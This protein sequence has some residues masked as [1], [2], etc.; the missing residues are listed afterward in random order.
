[1]FDRHMNTYDVLSKSTSKY[2]NKI[3]F[4]LEIYRMP[5]DALPDTSTV[6]EIDGYFPPLSFWDV[7]F[8]RAN[9]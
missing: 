2:S 7:L 3:V 9:C 6:P 5:Q 8:S 1:M 4:I